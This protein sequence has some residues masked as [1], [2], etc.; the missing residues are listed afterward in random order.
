MVFEYSPHCVGLITQGNQIVHRRGGREDRE[1]KDNKNLST[2]VPLMKIPISAK[3]PRP[4]APLC[5]RGLLGDFSAVVPTTAAHF[6]ARCCTDCYMNYSAV[7]FRSLKPKLY[8]A[9]VDR[10]TSRPSGSAIAYSPILHPSMSSWVMCPKTPA[11]N[12][13]GAASG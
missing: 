13:F 1:Q 7:I 8:A 4:T 12:S 10:S 9:R 5:K 11:A 3:I 6:H 2:S